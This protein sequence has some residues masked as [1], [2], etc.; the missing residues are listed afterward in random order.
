MIKENERKFLLDDIDKNPTKKIIETTSSQ[1][2][3]VKTTIDSSKKQTINTTLQR[4]TST[5]VHSIPNPKID[6]LPSV[7]LQIKEL[8]NQ[9]A[10]K[11]TLLL[12]VKSDLEKEISDKIGFL[13]EL[14]IMLGIL[15]NSLIAAG[16]YMLWL[17]FLLLLELLI[18]ISKLND[19]ESD[20]DKTIQEQ[21][22][23]HLKKINLL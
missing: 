13:D 3:I 22:E 18:L 15:K 12:N 7:D 14:D 6:Q 9:K 10:D 4:T 11:E 5:N 19:N 23:I 16:V 1:V 17:M 21:M 20:Y 2:P 8:S